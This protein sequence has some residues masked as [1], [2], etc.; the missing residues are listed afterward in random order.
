MDKATPKYMRFGNQNQ[1]QIIF[2]FSYIVGS[3]QVRKRI[4]SAANAVVGCIHETYPIIEIC[5]LSQTRTINPQIRAAWRA[6]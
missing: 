5:T 1:K 3:R 4:N 2:E 6:T